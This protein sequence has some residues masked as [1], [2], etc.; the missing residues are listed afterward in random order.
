MGGSRDMTSTTFTG[1]DIGDITD[2]ESSSEMTHS[3]WYQFDSTAVNTVTFCTK[4]AASSA[5]NIAFTVTMGSAPKMYV[6]GVEDSTTYISGTLPSGSDTFSTDAGHVVFGGF[7]STSGL[8]LNGR[9]VY[10]QLFD[11]AL[12]QP[13]IYEI[14]YKPGSIREN[15]I[16]F[17]TMLGDS[18][19][20]EKEIFKGRTGTVING[21]EFSDGPPIAGVSL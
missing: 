16:S 15:M 12:T 17:Q 8:E 3:A 7:D 18:G 1:L 10:H 6:N 9:T 5:G 20:S 19:T 14:M 11:R 2:F 13:E 21:A 4:W